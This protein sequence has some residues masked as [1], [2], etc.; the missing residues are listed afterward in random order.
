MCDP[1]CERLHV[2]SPSHL[3]Q[4]TRSRPAPTDKGGC[5]RASTS[6]SSGHAHTRNRAEMR[7]DARSVVIVLLSHHLGL[8][9]GSAL[10]AAFFLLDDG[11]GRRDEFHAAVAAV[12]A[13]VQ[14][15]VVVEVVL[16]VELVLSTELAGETV[17]SFSV[18]ASGMLVLSVTK[19]P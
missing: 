14:L 18:K 5:T 1:S 16:S 15:A 4:E 6:C 12:G 11:N 7:T 3:G 10:S 19:H 13:S 8:G 2:S 17:R 9:W